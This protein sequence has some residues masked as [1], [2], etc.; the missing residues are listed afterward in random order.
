MTSSPSPIFTSLAIVGL[1][2][3]T[4]FGAFKL[5]T[6]W[7]HVQRDWT[8]ATATQ[9]QT[10][11]ELEALRQSLKEKEAEVQER[12]EVAASREKEI[13]ELLTQ[14][15]H[16]EEELV[17]MREENKTLSKHT[18]VLGAQR[19]R[20]A[21]ELH[22]TK[23]EHKQTAELLEMRTAELKGAEMFLTKA[24]LLSN[25]EVVS[26][27]E[28][29][30]SEIMQ[31]AASMTE[32][33]P[34]EEKK[35]DLEG[36]EQES[37]EMRE[38]Y[39][40]AED[41][42]G[43]RMAELLKLSEHHEDPILVQLA[44]QASM[45]AYTHWIISS[46]V[47]ETPDDE[48][49]MSEIYARVRE[50]GKSTT[51]RVYLIDILTSSLEEQAVSGRWR[52]LTRKHLQRMLTS[53]PDLSLDMLGAVAN[54]FLTAGLKDTPEKVYERIITQFGSRVAVVMKLAV[55]LNRHIGEG[56]TSCDLEALY[57]APDIV[58]DPTTMEDAIGTGSVEQETIIC[59]T[60]LGLVRAEKI[61]GTRGDWKEAVL[62]KPKV[63][64]YSGIAG[65]VKDTD[66]PL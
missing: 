33:L 30:N 58:Y 10:A 3:A 56:I 4:L 60:D 16:V 14:A 21:A 27:L 40:R 47:F 31:I 39:A 37:D 7:E 5:K 66:S 61:A 13:E 46:W 34:I 57:I 23:T 49:M 35:I 63:V 36:K 45:T 20:L 59:T 64:L 43:P 42:V 53:D 6:L 15:R 26:L 2:V 48:H 65:I 17:A 22:A 19:E 32:E 24:D 11:Q 25:V 41:T 8:A 44:V 18:G 55:D 62:L 50:A 38:A 52:Q 12:A 9:K 54:I 51:D 28:N 1:S 29:L